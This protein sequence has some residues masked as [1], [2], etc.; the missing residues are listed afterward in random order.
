M[1]REPGRG[2][3]HPWRSLNGVAHV[4]EAIEP[5]DARLAF[6][7]RLHSLGHVLKP[8]ASV[9]ASASR[10][11]THLA[12]HGTPDDLALAPSPRPPAPAS[13]APSRTR[14]MPASS[15]SRTAVNSPLHCGTAPTDPRPS[16]RAT[17][18][19]TL[20]TTHSTRATGDDRGDDAPMLPTHTRPGDEAGL[21]KRHC[22]SVPVGRARGSSTSGL[23][24]PRIGAWVGSVEA[25]RLVGR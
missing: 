18:V 3:G 5:G 20:P 17:T 2:A 19:P 1:G 15:G 16:T 21:C 23:S 22:R 9:S 12:P 7:A 10:L 11:R 6:R 14:S 24:S 13:S 4:D 25:V 8:P